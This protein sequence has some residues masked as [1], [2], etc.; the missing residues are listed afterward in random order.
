MAMNRPMAGVSSVHSGHEATTT[1]LL[2]NSAVNVS[3]ARRGAYVSGTHSM[4]VV[5]SKANICAAARTIHGETAAAA[6]I[7]PMLSANRRDPLRSSGVD[8]IKV[9]GTGVGRIMIKDSPA[10][11]TSS[12]IAR[13]MSGS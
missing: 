7:V 1:S 10:N 13:L 11:G 4:G 9:P 2:S 12:S 8:G 5:E 6:R 3:Y